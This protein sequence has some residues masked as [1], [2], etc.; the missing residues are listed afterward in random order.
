MTTTAQV[1]QPATMSNRRANKPL[2]EKKRRERINQSLDLMKNL[3]LEAMNK[4]VSEF[5]KME[6]ADILEMTVKFIKD[7]HRSQT[8]VAAAPEPQTI[9]LHRTGYVECAKEV[10]RYISSTSTIDPQVRLR[11]LDHMANSVQSVNI[12][13]CPDRQCHPQ[14]QP[15]PAPLSNPSVIVPVVS[16]QMPVATSI[17]SLPGFSPVAMATQSVPCPQE[18]VL[19]NNDHN[20]SHHQGNNMNI[21]PCQNDRIVSPVPQSTSPVHQRLSPSF[22]TNSVAYTH[23]ISSSPSNQTAIT[24]SHSTNDFKM[25]QHRDRLVWRPW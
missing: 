20:I 16:V 25:V 9:K 7:I 8:K 19:V 13:S 23:Q 10:S 6:K 22:S 1:L 2:V 4:D 12:A 18:L 5:S 3:V 11:L 24:R 17:A 15:S 21:S 14:Q